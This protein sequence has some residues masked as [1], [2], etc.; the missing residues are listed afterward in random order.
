M[1]GKRKAIDR[2]ELE[3]DGTRPESTTPSHDT[4]VVAAAYVVFVSSTDRMPFLV[5]RLH[6][7][8][9]C[10]SPSIEGVCFTFE[11]EQG[12]SGRFYFFR[13]FAS[14]WP[15]GEASPRHQ[16]PTEMTAARV[17]GY[18]DALRQ[19]LRPTPRGISFDE[20]PNAILARLQSD[21]AG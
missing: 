9:A 15:D 8:T 10:R 3:T 16:I 13:Q 21:R 12:V 11:S 7:P 6:E 1:F 2:P 17:P 4:L 18:T 5:N 19:L 14:V 20:D